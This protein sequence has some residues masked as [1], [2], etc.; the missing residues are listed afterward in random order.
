MIIHG[1]FVIYQTFF[2]ADACLLEVKVSLCM[3]LKYFAT[4]LT[5]VFREKLL[6]CPHLE[7]FNLFG[8]NTSCTGILKISTT[9]QRNAFNA[10]QK[11]I[12][13]H[14]LVFRAK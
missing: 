3:L 5:Q 9:S 10:K 14:A 11:F 8:I 13:T 12:V 4:S 2:S 7:S 6:K 1:A